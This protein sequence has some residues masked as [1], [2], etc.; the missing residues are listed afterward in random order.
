MGW[1]LD[2]TTKIWKCTEYSDLNYREI[3]N[4]AEYGEPFSPYDHPGFDGDFEPDFANVVIEMPQ[5]EVMT[6]GYGQKVT[7]LDFP[8][9]KRFLKEKLT[10]PY[11]QYTFDDLVYLGFATPPS[12][13]AKGASSSPDRTISSNLY[14]D[15]LAVAVPGKISSADAS[16]IHGTVCF[17]L[18]KSTTFT[19]TA[20]KRQVQA[21]IGAGDDNW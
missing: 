20:K 1:S 18:M 10:F 17:K 13:W 19:Y 3:I 16:F 5:L 8:I 7:A 12:N 21:E 15:P 11:Q 14:G 6:N 4:L 2:Q 9:V